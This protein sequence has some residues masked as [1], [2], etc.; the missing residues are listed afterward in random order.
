M[1]N[2]WGRFCFTF[3]CTSMPAMSILSRTLN[4][5]PISLSLGTQYST[6]LLNWMADVK[7]PHEQTCC[8]PPQ[9][10]FFYCFFETVATS[11]Q[12]EVS[13]LCCSIFGWHLFDVS[14]FDEFI[15]RVDDVLLS[16]KPFINLQEFVHLLLELKRSDRK[17]CLSEGPRLTGQP[18]SPQAENAKEYWTILFIRL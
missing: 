15:G 18:S 14:L 9:V 2:V 4:F 13:V 10:Y 7:I 8:N 5:C 3:S 6:M 11:H 16:P 12:V 1:A 17:G